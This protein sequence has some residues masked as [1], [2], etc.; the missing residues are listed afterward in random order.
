MTDLEEVV[1]ALDKRITSM[2]NLI[3]ANKSSV[4]IGIKMGY[5]YA[6]E[7]V[8]NMRRQKGEL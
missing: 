2:T 8:Q 1:T 4:R 7:M 5:E 3:A 6:R